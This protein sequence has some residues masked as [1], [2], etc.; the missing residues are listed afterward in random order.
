[1]DISKP[2]MNFGRE[3]FACKCGCGF[4]T[5]DTSLLTVVQNIRTYFDAPVTILSGARCY[6]HNRAVGGSRNSQ[7]LFGRAADVVVKGVDPLE[8]RNY[9]EQ[10]LDGEGGIGYYPEK[11]FVHVDTR[12]KGGARWTG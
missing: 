12:T 7:H 11:G 8:V 3:E 2:S 10:Q 6:E 1:M 9:V 4:D 5:I